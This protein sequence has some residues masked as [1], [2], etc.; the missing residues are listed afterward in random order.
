MVVSACITP[1]W[2]PHASRVVFW[3]TTKR[4]RFWHASHPWG[5]RLRHVDDVDGEVAQSGAEGGGQ[6]AAAAF[7]KH[8]GRSGNLPMHDAFQTGWKQSSRDGGGAAASSA[9]PRCAE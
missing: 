8:D 9:R 3:L 5:R 1:G 7:H 4:G 2:A 6:V